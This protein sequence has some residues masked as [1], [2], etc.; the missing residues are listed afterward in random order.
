MEVLETL[1]GR[2][3]ELHTIEA[4]IEGGDE[5][6]A[7]LVLQGEPGIGKSTLMV[8]AER[9]AGGRDWL[10]L[11]A[12]GVQSETH[13]P[14]AGLHQLLRPILAGEDE[15]PESQRNALRAAFGAAGQEAPSLF[16]VALSTLGILG[17]AA[18]RQPILILAEDAHWLDDATCDVLAFIGRRLESEP[19]LLFV[20]RRDGADGPADGVALPALALGPLD[21]EA[22]AALLDLHAT[23][24]P[25]GVRRRLLREARGNP[26]AL[27]ELPLA[28][29]ASSDARLPFDGLPLT[30]RLEHAFAARAMALPAT[31]RALLLVA[32]LNDSED[33]R[34]ALVAAASVAG[35]AVRVADLAPAT[36]ALLVDADEGMLRFHHPLVR[37]AIRQA[38]TLA[39]RSA[40]H[41]AL[42]LVVA[43]DPDR[44]VWHRAA[45]TVG[46]DE[47][48]ATELEA[49]AARAASRGAL[50]AAAAA[51]E[52]AARLT[53]KRECLG[54]RLLQAAQIAVELGQREMATRL[55]RQAGQADLTPLDRGRQ[56]LIREMLDPGIDGDPARV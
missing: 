9:R 52:R 24:L 15:L 3:S 48:V 54:G 10:V 6:G 23:G 44:A 28:W 17:D 2:E 30:A 14:F 16:L 12:T 5:G 38:A 20:S 40:A 29:R 32:A 35:V 53:A 49:A 25:S 42:A 11:K 13:M 55:L 4:M 31:T 27:V 1:I 8:E 43:D 34:E 33:L 7:A 21:D 26:L 19:I 36:A 47:D 45:A 56:A 50:A 39:E 22:A 51:L 46:S 41:V 18:A 37:S